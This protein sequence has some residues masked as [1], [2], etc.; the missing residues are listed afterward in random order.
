ME[1]VYLFCLLNCKQPKNSELQGIEKWLNLNSLSLN[2]DKIKFMTIKSKYSRVNTINNQGVIIH[3]TR[4][5]QV[6]KFKHLGVIIDDR[7]MLSG[8]LPYIT[9]K[10]VKKVN[11]MGHTDI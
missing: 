5:G 2:T 10:I 4:I 8:H 7:V 11:F 3:G 6:N 9:K 1:R